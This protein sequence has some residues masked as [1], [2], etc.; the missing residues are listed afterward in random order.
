MSQRKRRKLDLQK[1]Q[2]SNIIT[3]FGLRI[4]ISP[5]FGN[6]VRTRPFFIFYLA[7]DVTLLLLPGKTK[8]TK[9]SAAG[10]QVGKFSEEELMNLAEA[11]ALSDISTGRS[12]AIS[13][14]EV[15]N[16]MRRLGQC[17]T[18][19]EVQEVIIEVEMLKR[20][21]H[22]GNEAKKKKG[23]RQDRGKRPRSVKS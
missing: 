5:L 16:A 1:V 6:R 21:R 9:K 3:A 11:F 20:S 18:Q 22:R 13:A 12:G 2:I 17:P 7:L 10:S 23:E 15:T 14:K 19:L 4:L 8:P